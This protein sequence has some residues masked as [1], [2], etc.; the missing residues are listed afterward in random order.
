MERQATT[1]SVEIPKYALLDLA[2]SGRMGTGELLSMTRQW[3][4]QV[5]IQAGWKE[6]LD[7]LR[8]K[9][10]D[11]TRVSLRNL[12]GDE[13]MNKIDAHISAAIKAVTGK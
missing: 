6:E 12:L 1:V 3:A 13:Q 9:R 5:C 10:L 8:K 11:E 4:E 2:A 7:E